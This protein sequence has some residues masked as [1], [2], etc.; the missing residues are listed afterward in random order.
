MSGRSINSII[1]VLDQTKDPQH[2]VAHSCRIISTNGSALDYDE[3]LL[4]ADC[5]NSGMWIDAGLGFA[6]TEDTAAFEVMQQVALRGSDIS[7]HNI[8]TNP[9]TN[10]SDAFKTIDHDYAFWLDVGATDPTRED[11]A[12]AQR[13]KL[14]VN[15][16]RLDIGFTNSY[17]LASTYVN[18]NAPFDK[19]LQAMHAD[20][21][22]VIRMWR[23]CKNQI[24]SKIENA[25]GVETHTK[26]Y[27]GDLA[28]QLAYAD[29]AILHLIGG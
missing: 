3:F 15:R 10:L 27:Y 24:V 12:T 7:A 16:A 29:D 9:E 13:F 6:I 17:E 23:K 25:G 26:K 11:E 19:D 28:T 5:F 4:F 8:E 20:I 18:H 14:D 2:R 21:A 22:D 1:I